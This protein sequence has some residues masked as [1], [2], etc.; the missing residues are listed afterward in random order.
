MELAVSGPSLWVYAY[1]LGITK[2]GLGVAPLLVPLLLEKRV[3]DWLILPWY[4]QSL[5]AVML[6]L[7]WLLFTSAH[8]VVALSSFHPHTL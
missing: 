3:I 6:Q 7:L 5:P 4:H 1:R 8:Q 2:G